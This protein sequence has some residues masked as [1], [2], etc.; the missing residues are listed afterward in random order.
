M[1]SWAVIRLVIGLCAVVAF[2]SCITR[3]GAGVITSSASS[4]RWYESQPDHLASEC[5]RWEERIRLGMPEQ[6]FQLI[7]EQDSW[8]SRWMKKP[9]RTLSSA[10]LRDWAE[11]EVTVVGS[12]CHD[13]AFVTT[14]STGGPFHLFSAQGIPSTG[15]QLTVICR[16]DEAGVWRVAYRTV[17]QR[18]CF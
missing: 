11:S 15:H 2:S 13:P 9:A 17:R 18:P 5:E 12:I 7:I 4:A 10:E 14:V 1:Y 16:V 6:E 3:Q 8:A